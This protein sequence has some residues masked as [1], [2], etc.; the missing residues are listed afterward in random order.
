MTDIV[1]PLSTES[2]FNNLQLRIALRSIQKYATN[3]GNIHIITAAPLKQ[4]KD[5]NIIYQQDTEKNLKDVNLINK[6]RTAAASP[7]VR[8]NFIFWSDDQLLTAPL[9]LDKA[10][11]VSNNRAKA[12][13]K[14]ETKWQKR[15]LNTLQYVEKVT[16]KQLP[17]NYDSHVPQP[18]N[19]TDV[20]KVF[21]TLNYTQQPGF[22]INTIYYG[23]L[24]KQPTANQSNVKHTFQ[25][26]FNRVPKEMLLYAG[27]DDKSFAAG[28]S[29][30]FLGMFYNKS[31]YELN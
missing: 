23:L 30:F 13:I 18:Y 5:V 6:I 4:L 14:G 11:I 29:H 8:Q 28:I 31:K 19:K 3:L 26:G 10:P 2:R 27:Y 25:G 20:S 21:S 9:D 24:Q 1:I 22:C 17:Y 12:D 7:D 15:L 16:G